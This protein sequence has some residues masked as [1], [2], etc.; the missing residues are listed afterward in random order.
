MSAAESD[1]RASLAAMEQLIFNRKVA[2]RAA[3]AADEQ[4]VLRLQ[5]RIRV[6]RAAAD[7]LEQELCDRHNA[8]CGQERRGEA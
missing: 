1:H 5:E 6:N 7:G 2:L 3:V 4:Q 8:L